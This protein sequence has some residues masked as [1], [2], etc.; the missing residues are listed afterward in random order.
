MANLEDDPDYEPKGDV[1]ID[2]SLALGA[3][4]D[5]SPQILRLY[6]PNKDRNGRRIWRQRKWI[7]EA[8]SLLATLG[9]GVT[10]MPRVRGGWYD[11]LNRRIIWERPVVVYT[12]IKPHLFI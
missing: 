4:V 10:I 9:G 6:I 11:E 5:L 2:L 7:D 12:Y 1:E 8:A 3:S